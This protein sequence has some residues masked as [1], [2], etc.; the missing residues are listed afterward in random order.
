[1]LIY[2]VNIHNYYKEYLLN[3]HLMMDKNELRENY[4]YFCD[5]IDAIERK[6]ISEARIL[7]QNHV[8]RHSRRRRDIKIKK[9]GQVYH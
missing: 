1:M 6:H 8:L 4:H 3:K 2:I 5:V 7:S 9:G